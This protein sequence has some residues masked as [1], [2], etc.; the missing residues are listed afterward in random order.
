MKNRLKQIKSKLFGK[1]DP[2]EKQRNVIRKKVQEHVT[3]SQ[4]QVQS[5]AYPNG[6]RTE[7]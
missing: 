7:R 5:T 4:P 6:T 1:V 2:I 3:K